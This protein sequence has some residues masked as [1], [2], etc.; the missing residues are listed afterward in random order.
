MKFL[1]KHAGLMAVLLLVISLFAFTRFSGMVH[2]VATGSMEP[3]LP[4][5]TIVVDHP[6]DNLKVGDVITFREAGMTDPV[7]HRLIQIE[8]DGSLVTQGDANPTP[9]HPDVP[10]QKSDVI[11]QVWFQI[12]VMVPSFWVSI[13]GI[14][15]MVSLL[16]G[17]VLYVTKD[18]KKE[19]ESKQ[20]DKDREETLEPTPV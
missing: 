14:I 15:L 1:R 7:T 5:H 3:T 4:V 11:G 18:N 17:I 16:G 13:P 20:S 9:D 2:T 6:V 12:Q 8:K 10:L 19:D